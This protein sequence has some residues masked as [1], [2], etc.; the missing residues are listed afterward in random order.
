MNT[1]WHEV[2]NAKDVARD[3][4]RYGATNSFPVVPMLLCRT[5]LWEADVTEDPAEVTCKGCRRQLRKLQQ[6]PPPRATVRY[7]LLAEALGDELGKQYGWLSE[8][9]RKLGIDVSQLKRVLAGK[10]EVGSE[11]IERAVESLPIRSSYFFD[12]VVTDWH[13]YAPRQ[14]AV[15]PVSCAEHGL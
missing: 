11:V 10:G 14:E 9:A 3:Q 15:L 4:A 6:L 7:Q 2:I 5:R 8:V 12:A 1:H 13:E